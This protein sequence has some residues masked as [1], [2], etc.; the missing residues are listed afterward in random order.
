MVSGQRLEIFEKHGRKTLDC[1]EYTVSIK[2]EIWLVEVQTLKAVLSGGNEDHVIENWKK[3]IL[4]IQGQ[5]S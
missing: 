3:E 4:V 5:K 2:I 1:L